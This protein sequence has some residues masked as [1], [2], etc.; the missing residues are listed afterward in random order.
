MK[1]NLKEVI[2]PKIESDEV[3]ATPMQEDMFSKEKSALCE[4][5]SNQ[6][7]FGSKSV[8]DLYRW[9]STGE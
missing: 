9:Q 3:P 2:Y 5:S 4:H 7:R 6:T 1:G 8:R